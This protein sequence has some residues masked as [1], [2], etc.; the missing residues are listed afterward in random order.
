MLDSCQLQ[1]IGINVR[2]SSIF[3]NQQQNIFFHVHVLSSAD[4]TLSLS[5]DYSYAISRSGKQKYQY[6]IMNLFAALAGVNKVSISTAS[7]YGAGPHNHFITSIQLQLA[8][9]SK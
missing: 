6:F 1:S 8:E 7:V 2:C 3:L 9:N 4:E 5:T